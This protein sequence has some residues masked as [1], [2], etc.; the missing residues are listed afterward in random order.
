[1]R[2]GYRFICQFLHLFV[3]GPF[4]GLDSSCSLVRSITGSDKKLDDP[5]KRSPYRIDLFGSN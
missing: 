2:I 5:L 4:V 1:M 3:F